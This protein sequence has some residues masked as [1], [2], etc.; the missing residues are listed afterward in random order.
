MGKFPCRYKKCKGAVHRGKCPV[1]SARGK[2]GGSKTGV[3]KARTGDSNGRFKHG[4]RTCCNTLKTS[5]H[6]IDCSHARVSMRKNIQ[7]KTNI[8]IVEIKIPKIEWHSQAMSVSAVR[9][10]LRGTDGICQ[11]TCGANIPAI[12]ASKIHPD[13]VLQNPAR[14]ICHACD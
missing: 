13:D 1:A 6:D 11:G 2:K 9:N 3:T 5:P 8:P 4:Y 10:M 7:V 14:V 12:Q